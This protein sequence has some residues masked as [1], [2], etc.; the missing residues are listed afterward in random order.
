MVETLEAAD[1]LSQRKFERGYVREDCVKPQYFKRLIRCGIPDLQTSSEAIFK[2]ILAYRQQGTRRDVHVISNSKGAVTLMCNVDATEPA[3]YRVGRSMTGSVFRQNA[4]SECPR[5]TD[6]RTR[7]TADFQIGI[8]TAAAAR[9]SEY[10]PS[11]TTVAV[12]DG[13]AWFLLG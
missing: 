7:S 2:D 11:P 3:D 9:R 13:R 6:D 5:A 12:K 1:A 4:A 10:L 8:R